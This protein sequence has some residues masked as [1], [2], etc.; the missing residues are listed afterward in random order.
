MSLRRCPV[1]TLCF[2]RCLLLSLIYL[3]SGVRSKETI[4][5]RIQMLTDLQGHFSGHGGV[6][7]ATD[8]Y[9]DCA[10]HIT[11]G[12]SMQAIEFI[13]D[14][15]AKFV[16]SDRLSIYG[17]AHTDRSQRVATFHA[18]NPLPLSGMA[19]TGSDE[20]L[21]VLSAQSNRT[22]FRIRYTCRPYGIKLGNS[23]F[24]PVGYA[25][26]FAAFIVLAISVAVMPVYLV[27]YCKAR[28]QQDLAMQESQLMVRSELARRMRENELARVQEQ[29]VM[30]SLQALPTEQW[31]D[32]EVEAGQNAGTEECCLC[33]EPFSPED[34]LRLLPCH[35]FFHQACIDSWFSARRFMPRS[36]PL[37]KRNPIVEKAPSRSAV[38]AEEGS[39]SLEAAV[40]TPS[41][42]PSV[43]PEPAVHQ[44]VLTQVVSLPQTS[45]RGDVGAITESTAAAVLGRPQQ[46]WAA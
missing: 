16:G 10:W 39:A 23:W 31:K 29:L 27:C 43:E 4:Y 45:S 20:A 1:G 18:G 37:C 15:D 14:G 2:L 36:C 35:H 17:S 46:A 7:G 19:L 9:S 32:H 40:R 6:H 38:S 3:P 33:L 26:V 28:R 24:S 30:A 22:H 13:V 42:V 34:R 12:L 21:F 25:C 44:A 41:P 11:P 5:C 8:S